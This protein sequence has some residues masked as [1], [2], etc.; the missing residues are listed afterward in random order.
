[1]TA[2]SRQQTVADP[3]GRAFE[4]L[5]S[6]R[7]RD[8]GWDCET[9]L[10][11]DQLHADLIC[12]YRD[13]KAVL[14]CSPG[15]DVDVAD[16]Q[17]AA[18]MKAYHGAGLAL[19]V[20]AEDPGARARSMAGDMGVVLVAPG[21]LALASAYDRTEYGTRLRLEREMAQRQE[22]RFRED[23]AKR[24]ALLAH[25]EALATYE[26]DCKA[27]QA[28]VRRQPWLKAASVASIAPPFLLLGT[29]YFYVFL[30]L[31]L[32]A[33]AYALFFSSPGAAPVAPQPIEDISL[34]ELLPERTPSGT[35]RP[36]PALR[37][38]PGGVPAPATLGRREKLYKVA[39]DNLKSI[40]KCPRCHTKMRLP[41]GRRV[42]ANC[43][44]CKNR[45][46]ADT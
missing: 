26:R 27:W 23:A 29:P 21:E 25:Y 45:F 18:A 6:A 4:R 37:A 20:H 17:H 32:A 8:L 19:I 14:Q 46:R 31:A 11:S 34:L 24:A 3:A 30:A 12:T 7:M 10:V 42:W 40:V 35:A 22:A 39:T 1:M 33:S 9:V 2:A 5:V 38:G 15:G 13:E 43:P 28:T 44:S 41:R 36:N 16:M